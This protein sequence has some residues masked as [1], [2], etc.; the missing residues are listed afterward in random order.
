MLIFADS[1][2]LYVFK[3]VVNGIS[4]S[5]WVRNSSYNIE[6]FSYTETSSIASIGTSAI[7]VR[8]N[9]FVNSAF[10]PLTNNFRILSFWA[11]FFTSMFNTSKLFLLTSIFPFSPCAIVRHWSYILNIPY[12]QSLP[13]KRAD[14][15]FC[16]RSR[17]LQ[18]RAPRSANFNINEFYSA[19]PCLFRNNLC[20]LHCSIWACFL[21]LRLYNHASGAFC[22]CFSPAYISKQKDCVVMACIYV[23]NPPPLPLAHQD[24]PPSIRSPSFPIPSAFSAGPSACASGPPASAFSSAFCSAGF[25][26]ISSCKGFP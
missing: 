11:I 2:F 16:P 4:A 6:E 20:N 10:T 26:F 25:C 21:V 17:G 14:C 1:P 8:R 22:N 18:F 12:N 19:L 7:I 24:A 9:A 15:R 3:S 5:L 23:K 13:C